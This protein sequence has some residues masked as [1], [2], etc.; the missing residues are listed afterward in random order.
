MTYADKVKA[1]KEAVKAAS[2]TL[3]EE[4]EAARRAEEADRAY[5]DAKY[6]LS[7]HIKKTIDPGESVVVGNRV[8]TLRPDNNLWE[9]TLVKLRGDS[10]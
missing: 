1:F 10:E 3:A 5:E 7:E 8:F 6:A 9:T 2:A 4:A